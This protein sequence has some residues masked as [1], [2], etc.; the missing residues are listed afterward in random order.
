VICKQ[1]TF[2]DAML[3]YY[4][5]SNLYKSFSVKFESKYTRIVKRWVVTSI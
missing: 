5:Y 3:A 2:F 1:E 4:C